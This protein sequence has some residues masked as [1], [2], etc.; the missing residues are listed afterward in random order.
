MR[1]IILATLVAVGIGLV[2]TSNLSAAP[3]NGAMIDRTAK[4]D[5]MVVKVQH[6]RKYS[7]WRWGSGYRGGCHVSGSSRWVHC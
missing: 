6:Y 2:G 3:A 7:H 4:A 5:N 1:A